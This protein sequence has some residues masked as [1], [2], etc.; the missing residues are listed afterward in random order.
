[1]F[2]NTVAKAPVKIKNFVPLYPRYLP[3]N[4]IVMDVNKVKNTPSEK[5]IL[6][7][8][9]QFVHPITNYIN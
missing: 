6:S 9:L 3:V 1:M 7:I 8:A 2:I 4:P 5:V